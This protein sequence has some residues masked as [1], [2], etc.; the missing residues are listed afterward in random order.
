MSSG[1][2]K[3]ED[4]P[5]NRLTK[6]DIIANLQPTGNTQPFNEIVE[7]GKQTGNRMIK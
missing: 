6:F 7:N 4:F 1:S 2:D 3:F 5:Q